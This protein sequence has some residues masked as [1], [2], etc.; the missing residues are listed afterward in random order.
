MI[1]LP[2]DSETFQV[3]N[4]RVFIVL[5]F[6][7]H[8]VHLCKKVDLLLNVFI[9]TYLQLSLSDSRYACNLDLARYQGAFFINSSVLSN[10]FSMIMI[11][12]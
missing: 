5:S 10:F 3:Y 4:F 6:S 12:H 8:S 7:M 1:Y 2:C 9:L 11:V